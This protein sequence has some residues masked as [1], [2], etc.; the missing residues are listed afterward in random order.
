VTE[1]DKFPIFLQ[2]IERMFSILLPF[3]VKVIPKFYAFFGLHKPAG[4]F[5]NSGFAMLDF[6]NGTW[7][8]VSALLKHISPIG[9][10]PQIEMKIKHNTPGKINMEPEN[11][12]LEKENHLPNHHFQVLC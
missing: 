4:Q 1:T 11:T 3:E 7:L 6:P 8:V 10:L 5:S 2:I 12:P 9:N